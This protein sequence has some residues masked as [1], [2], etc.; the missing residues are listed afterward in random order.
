MELIEILESSGKSSNT[1]KRVLGM[2]N[3]LHKPL[4][5]Q[6][7]RK[8]M[9]WVWVSGVEAN[10]LG[11]ERRGSAARCSKTR[12]KRY[13]S[14]SRSENWL[15][16]GVAQMSVDI[17]GSIL[18]VESQGTSAPLCILGRTMFCGISSE[19]LNFTPKLGQNF[20]LFDVITSFSAVYI[21]SWTSAQSNP[22]TVTRGS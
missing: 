21:W 13:Q 9:N 14:E 2:R 19:C 6:R 12:L 20:S 8:Q 10:Y 22:R 3:V 15:L 5:Q 4:A 17:R 18:N 7:Q 16:Y 1:A 11:D